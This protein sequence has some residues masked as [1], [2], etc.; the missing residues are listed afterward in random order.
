MCCGCRYVNG[1]GVPRDSRRGFDLIRKASEAGN[2]D[3]LYN[4]GMMYLTVRTVTSLPVFSYRAVPCSRCFVLT[5]HVP[6]ARAAVPG[7]RQ[8]RPQLQERAASAEPRVL[9]GTPRRHVRP[10]PGGW[11][12]GWPSGWSDIP[13]FVLQCAPNASAHVRSVT[14]R[15]CDIQMGLRG[16]GGPPS[17]DKAVSYFK[18]VALKGPWCVIA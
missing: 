16:I 12:D 8:G 13:L 18:S 11:P 1:L 7:C 4:M 17:C 2:P 5:C 3:A 6:W 9:D 10:W 15:R 14:V